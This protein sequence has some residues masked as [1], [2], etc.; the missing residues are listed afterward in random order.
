MSGFSRDA[1]SDDILDNTANSSS[2]GIITNTTSS[3]ND[4]S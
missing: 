4:Y 3:G 2:N 1:I